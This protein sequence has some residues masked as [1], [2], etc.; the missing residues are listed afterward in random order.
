MSSPRENLPPCSL[1]GPPGTCSTAVSS[2][3]SRISTS[4]GSEVAFVLYG[5]MNRRDWRRICT[6]DIDFD[7]LDLT[8]QL[9]PALHI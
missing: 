7:P 5:A 8:R 2:S 4:K 9:L 3:L 6:D 1:A